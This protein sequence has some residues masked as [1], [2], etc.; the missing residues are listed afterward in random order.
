M[1]QPER[2]APHGRPLRVI[3]ERLSAEEAEQVRATPSVTRFASHSATDRT[4]DADPP[5]ADAAASAPTTVLPGVGGPTPGA[6]VLQAAP[7]PPP[8][9]APGLPVLAPY[10]PRRRVAEIVRRVFARRHAGRHRPE[11]TTTSSWS[12]FAPQRRRTRPWGRR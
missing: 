9:A 10:R 2:P 1:S 4:T 12:M 8:V 3:S 11:T 7:A 5:G 6:T